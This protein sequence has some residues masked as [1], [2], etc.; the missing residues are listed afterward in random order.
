MK[1]Y[2]F[3]LFVF[4]AIMPSVSAQDI[5]PDACKSIE[6]EI[7]QVA[8]TQV[9]NDYTLIEQLGETNHV[10]I[11]QQSLEKDLNVIL[12]G[13][14]G[15]NNNGYIHQS[16][17][18]HATG[19]RQDG[20]NNEANLWSEGQLTLT[21]VHQEGEGNILNSFIDNQGYLPKAAAIQQKGN[22]NSIELALIGNGYFNASFPKAAVITQEGDNHELSAK[23]ESF[24]SPILIE[25][26]AGF[27]GEGMKVNISNSDFYFPTK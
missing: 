21:V 3:I 22:G 24:G 13:Q 25:Q 2:L 10:Q 15:A 7:E 4:I 17:Y 6:A 23:L 1:R 27:G 14:D 8:A 11:I 12:T 5:Q 16:G 19:L 20:T 18:K 9:F 26:Q